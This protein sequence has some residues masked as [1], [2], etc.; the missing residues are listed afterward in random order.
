MW[1]INSLFSVISEV[2]SVKTPFK[3]AATV[4]F[5]SLGPILSATCMGVT[6]DSKDLLDLS[7]N[8]ISI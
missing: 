7:G 1:R 8:V 6:P 4:S 3:V 5:A 2:T